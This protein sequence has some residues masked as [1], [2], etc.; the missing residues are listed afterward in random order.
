MRRGLPRVTTPWPHSGR[1]TR[2]PLR[3]PSRETSTSVKRNL[4][5]GAPR[6]GPRGCT[7]P[8][9]MPPPAVA[10]PVVPSPHRF[11]ERVL[12]VDLACDEPHGRTRRAQPLSYISAR[13]T[14][15]FPGEHRSAAA[16]G[17]HYQTTRTDH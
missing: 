14:A 2:P 16:V 10:L 13:S 12:E 8:H 5:S 17:V 11:G 7:H 15:A 1:Q 3:A 4:G 9:A 6:A